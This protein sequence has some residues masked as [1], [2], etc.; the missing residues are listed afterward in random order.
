MP[1]PS[2]HRGVAVPARP[3]RKP[4]A[5]TLVGLA[6]LAPIVACER[7]EEAVRPTRLVELA[8]DMYQLSLKPSVYDIPDRFAPAELSRTAVQTCPM[9]YVRDR[10][11]WTGA[12]GDR[13]LVWEIRCNG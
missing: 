5:A 8:P 4:L 13:T 12:A 2:D 6:L 7:L 9:G 3:V 1:S 10:E 11:W